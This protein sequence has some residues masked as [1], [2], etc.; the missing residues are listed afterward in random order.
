MNLANLRTRSRSRV[1]ALACSLLAACGLA[2]VA[3]SATLPAAEAAPNGNIVALGDSFSANP[4]QVRNTLRGSVV[5]GNTP[6]LRDYPKTGGCLQGPDNWPR[7][8]QATGAGPVADWSCTAQ[9]SRTMLGRING[10]I[11][12]GDLHRGT[13][14]VVM[15]I[16]MNNYGPF[17]AKDGV[18]VLNHTAVANAY[19]ADMKT[20]AK[21]IRSVAPQ[22]KL[23]IV[24]TL[25][26]TDARGNYC[27][28]NVVPNAPLPLSMNLI[29]NAERSNVAMQARAAREIG[30][31]FV[32]MRGKTYAQHSSCAPDKQRYVAGVIDTTTPNYNMM[33]HPSREGSRFIARNVA[34]VL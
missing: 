10:A 11:K 27:A 29:T 24:G 3:P 12:A 16:G 1:A 4:D 21:R 14:S 15:A 25:A 6:Y 26:V 7:L 17:G 19:V 2:V 8:L 32:E 22:A 20:A 23:V 33:F 9:T 34:A 31:Q 5:L 18:D 30:A 13:K 28:I